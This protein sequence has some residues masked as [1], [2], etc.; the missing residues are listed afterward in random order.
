MTPLSALPVDSAL[1]ATVPSDRV[2]RAR[3]L[4]IG[5]ALA[6][7]ATLG[8]AVAVAD[9]RPLD[10]A[11]TLSS[12]DAC[13]ARG[14]LIESVESW[15]RRA[16]VD[17]DL[18]IVVEVA[19]GTASVVVL[20]LREP[21]AARRFDHLPSE[22]A[23]RRAVLGLAIA[24]AIDAALI[25]RLAERAA[26]SSA[27]AA[28]APLSE[29]PTPSHD[30]G[31]PE[32][33]DRAPDLALELASEGA[34][35]IGALPDPVARFSVSAALL[36]RGG[37]RIGVTLLA[38]SPA[39]IPVRA[40]RV[41]AWIALA[42]VE[43]CV[44]RLDPVLEL[45]GCAALGGGAVL[46]AGRGYSPGYEVALPTFSGAAR[47]EATLRVDPALGLSLGVDAAL[48]FPETS[49]SVIAPGGEPLASVIL[50]TASV[51]VGLG[52]RVRI[53]SP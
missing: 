23:D 31:G 47:I 6:T 18:E 35:A 51:T 14:A 32:H 41:D 48:A 9:E 46:A 8:T 34:L 43:A 22:C 30:E 52:A 40:G 50:P 2:D 29:P 26:S 17:R 4:G 19:G 44:V 21:R 11:I 15:L 37:A 39:S 28:V 49:L 45:A 16:D 3:R 27:R 5:L 42:R 7:F 20:A 1:R 33:G 36:A 53:D 25:D 10:A 12:D 13:V 38:T 24:I